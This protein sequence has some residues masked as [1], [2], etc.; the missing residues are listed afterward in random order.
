MYSGGRRVGET[1]YRATLERRSGK[2]KFTLKCEG[3][4]DQVVTVSA[5]RDYHERVKLERKPRQP[6]E[7]VVVV[8]PGRCR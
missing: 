2:T 3:Y 1:T 5:E 6:G 8:D 4:R 7:P